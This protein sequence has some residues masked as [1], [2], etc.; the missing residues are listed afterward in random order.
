MY[1]V[2]VVDILVVSVTF[3][4]S[5]PTV[6]HLSTQPAH[7]CTT[8][9]GIDL[10]TTASARASK[11]EDTCSLW[12]VTFPLPWMWRR[13]YVASVAASRHNT[14][15]G[16]ASLQE[17]PPVEVVR[18]RRTAERSSWTLHKQCLMLASSMDL[19]VTCTSESPWAFNQFEFSFL[20]FSSKKYSVRYRAVK[21]NY[22]F[23]TFGFLVSDSNISTFAVLATAVGIL[24]ILTS[25]LTAVFW[26]RYCCYWI[27]T[28][29]VK[30]GY[31]RTWYCC[32][33]AQSCP[34]LCDPM[35][36]SI[37][38]FPVSHCLLEFAQT[39][40]LWDDEPC[41]HLIL[42]CPLLLLPSIFPSIWVFS[43]G[44]ALHIRWPKF[45]SFSFR[46]GFL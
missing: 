5:F 29:Q 20:L 14:A 23:Q 45:W 38:G 36:C 44:S 31:G 46:V 10:V 33:V 42:C 39:H 15:V 22:V 19:S 11:A 18:T 17:R 21:F 6:W 26:N 12:E 7:S 28:F 41:K 4:T 40:V 30:I 16:G 2:N 9:H 8:G 32:S 24:R 34:T 25:A 27:A 1:C 35:N 3:V 43:S 13:K 37:P